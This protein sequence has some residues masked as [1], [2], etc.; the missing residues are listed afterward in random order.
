MNAIKL[1]AKGLRI[2]CLLFLFV[3]CWV[4]AQQPVNEDE[5]WPRVRSTNGNTVTLYE[6]QVENWSSNWFNASAVIEV[7]PANTKKTLLG[8]VWFDAYGHVDHSNRLVTLDNFG[9]T[10]G[11]FPDATDGGSNALALARELFPGG[12]RTVSLDYLITALGFAQAAGRQEA[13]HGL[14][15]APPDI[16]WSTNLAV[17]VLIDGEPVLRPI[18]GSTLERVINTPALMVHDKAANKF[19]LSGNDQWFSADS[20]TGQWSLV[21]VPPPEVAALSPPATNGSPANTGGA[22]PGSSLTRG[23]GNCS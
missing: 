4:L 16:I 7:K 9:I 1:F 3:P 5:P 2:A 20:I 13:S 8:V 22:T 21:Q 14:G 23:P 18:S 10:R 6:P 19:Y 17:L 15:H 12:A 11:S